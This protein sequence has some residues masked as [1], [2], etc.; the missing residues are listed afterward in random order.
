MLERFA[1]HALAQPEAI[2]AATDTLVLTY[3]EADQLSLRIAAQLPDSRSNPGVVALIAARH[4]FLTA[5]LLGVIRSGHAFHLIEPKYPLSRIQQCLRYVKPCAVLDVRPDPAP[6]DDPFASLE[7]EFPSA[8]HIRITECTEAHPSSARPRIP[9]EPGPD[10][11]LYVAFTSGTTGVP[12]AVWGGHAPISHF[13]EW[14]TTTFDIR[15]HDRVSVLSGLAHDPLLR[16]VLMPLWAGASA[17][18]P[19]PQVYAEPGTLFEW[20][21]E[22]KI[23]VMH[24]T[25]SLAHLALRVPRRL[26]SAT[27][28]SLRLAY[29][30]GEPLTFQLARR[31]GSRAPEARL[32]TCYGATET[33]QVMAFHEVTPGSESQLSGLA[34][35]D[36]V[37]VGQGIDGVELLVLDEKQVPCPPG[38]AGEICIRTPYRA[39]KVEDIHGQPTASYV[40]N[41]ATHDPTDLLYRTGDF[42][43]ELPHGSVA[44]SG[45]RDRQVKIRGFRIDLSEIEAQVAECPGVGR[46]YLFVHPAPDHDS[47]VLLVNASGAETPTTVGI[48]DWLRAR[49]P[50]YMVPEHI[51]LVDPFPVTPNGK[52]DG[53]QLRERYAP[54]AQASPPPLASSDASDQVAICQRIAHSLGATAGTLPALDSLRLVELSCALEDAFGVRIA[55]GELKGKRT[56]A[57]LAALVK[58][59]QGSDTAMDSSTSRRIPPPPVP[60]PAPPSSPSLLPRNESILRGVRNRILQLL[61]RVAP[62]ALRVRFHRWRGVQIGA[63]ASI[64]YDN[65]IETSYPWLVALGAHVNIGM[66]VTIIAH[67]RGMG[68]MNQGPTVVIGDGAFVGPGVIILPNVRIGAGAVISAGSV[69]STDI[70]ELCFAQG[71]PARVVARC[72]IPLTGKTTYYEFLDRLMPL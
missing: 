70:P 42:G 65:I 28:T 15:R 32:I 48:A 10:D 68:A 45:R 57:D 72:G 58:Q 11:V 59:R 3:A 21:S 66:R 6:I 22:M 63:G 29:F 44:F 54:S 5:A 50:E 61:A 9:A 18:F 51:A 24:L 14:Q 41:P 31:F 47:L 49:L 55:V 2:C 4:P 35:A 60:I 64:G 12:K 37:P 30:G 1:H 19:P 8:T 25:P 53:A 33:P 43:V 13:F 69:V 38:I 39:L 52:I 67:F 36:T 56:P 26:A 62:D 16:D 46:C 7:R 23:S 34:A 17:H 27:L 71:N 20:L 40:V